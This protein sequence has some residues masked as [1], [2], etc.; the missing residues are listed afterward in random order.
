MIQILLALIMTVGIH[1]STQGFLIAT[2]ILIGIVLLHIALFVIS[3]ITALSLIGANISHDEKVKSTIRISN[4]ILI[5]LF[6]ALSG[7][8]LYTIGYTLLVGMLVISLP[9]TMLATIIIGLAEGD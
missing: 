3:S 2:N 6:L 1:F 8:H 5:Q 9:V 4:K 7:Y